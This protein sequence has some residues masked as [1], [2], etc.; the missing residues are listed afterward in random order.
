MDGLGVHVLLGETLLDLLRR[1]GAGEDPDAVYAE[2]W[3]N[4]DHWSADTGGDDDA[5]DV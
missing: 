4:A 1:V 2:M 3:A 5:V